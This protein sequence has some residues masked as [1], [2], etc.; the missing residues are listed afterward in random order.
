M[1]ATRERSRHGVVAPFRKAAATVV[2]TTSGLFW[3]VFAVNACFLAL[4]A[5][6]LIV[7]P[8]TISAPIAV[9]EAALVVLGLAI[10]L[11]AN[12]VLLRR[13]FTPLERL[14]RRMEVVDPLRPGE[15]LEVERDDEIGR[16]GAFN[17]MLDRLESER[18]ESATRV[19]AA[20]EAVRLGIARDLHDE[21]G[22]VLTGALL[23]LGAI[24]ADGPAGRESLEEARGSSSGIA[25]T[26]STSSGCATGSS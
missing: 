26:S 4:V 2:V 9:T 6:L 12:A 13:V 10:A 21:V 14:V 22:Q 3:R 25:R 8:V 16:V 24:E 20:Q 19:L 15:R 17:R 11:L 1:V 5:V 18:R 7:T 23:Q